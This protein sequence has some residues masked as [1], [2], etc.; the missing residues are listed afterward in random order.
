MLKKLVSLGIAKCEDEEKK[1]SK[2][3]KSLDDNY[4]GVLDNDTIKRMSISF[5]D[6]EIKVNDNS[7]LHIE[8]QDYVMNSLDWGSLDLKEMIS[9]YFKKLDKSVLTEEEIKKEF[10]EVD[11]NDMDVF[12]KNAD[13]DGDKIFSQDELFDY[14]N[15]EIIQDEEISKE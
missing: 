9:F 13:V 15:K 5:S 12:I 2:E 1:F 7:E 8:Y 14:L 11:E 3:F 6:E 4:T 10:K